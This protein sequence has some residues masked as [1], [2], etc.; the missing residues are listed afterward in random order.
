MDLKL[1]KAVP[2]S[3]LLSTREISAAIYTTVVSKMSRQLELGLLLIN[4]GVQYSNTI[5]WFPRAN[6]SFYV[7]REKWYINTVKSM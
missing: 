5:P 1:R 6:G 3:E 2:L 4:S 7:S